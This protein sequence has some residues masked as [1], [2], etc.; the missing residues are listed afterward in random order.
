[1]TQ[2]QSHEEIEEFFHGMKN[3]FGEKKP[4]GQ[5]EKEKNIRFVKRMYRAFSFDFF[6]TTK[7]ETNVGC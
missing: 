4:T 5:K 3:S 1:M 2:E 7:S 6:S